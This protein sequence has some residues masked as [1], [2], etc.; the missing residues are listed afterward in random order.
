MKEDMIIRESP[1]KIKTIMKAHWKAKEPFHLSAEPSTVKSAMILLTAKEINIDENDNREFIEWSKCDI[2]KKY[3]IL[4]NPNNYFIFEDLR[5]SETDIGELRLQDMNKENDYITYKYN[6]LFKVLSNQYSKGVLFF[7]EMNLANNMIK[8]QFY[9]VYNDRSIG[10]M[11]ISKDILVCSAG[12]ESSQV[13]DVVQDSVALTTRRGNYFIRPLSSDEFIEYGLKTGINKSIIGYISFAPS[14]VHGL[15]YDITES[16]GQ[17]CVRTWEKLS[18]ILNNN[19]DLSL[20]EKRLLSRG[21]IGQETASK[22]SGFIELENSIKLQDVIDKPELVKDIKEI[23]IQYAIMAGLLGK[24]NEIGDKLFPTMC[25]V[26]VNF[27]K[28]EC[29]VYLM[30]TLKNLVNTDVKKL[31]FRKLALEKYPD[32]FNVCYNKYGDLLRD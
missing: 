5:A 17:P 3:E 19:E 10:D 28:E 21:L 13:Y 12:N 16:Q 14:D 30:S 20:D 7:D 18:N 24:Y 15:R 23:Q 27:I 31:N 2:K 8:A 29:G 25:K 11:P 32:E 1:L 9:K 4:E 6:L 26:S 22:F